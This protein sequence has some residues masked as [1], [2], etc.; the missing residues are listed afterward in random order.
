MLPLK[1]GAGESLLQGGTV[2]DFDEMKSF[3]GDRNAREGRCVVL[4]IPGTRLMSCTIVLW[5]TGLPIRDAAP[6]HAYSIAD[7]RGLS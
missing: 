1:F 7:Q 5:M 4:G 6:W 3:V 2:R